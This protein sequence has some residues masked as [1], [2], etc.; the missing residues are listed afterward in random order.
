MQV[1]SDVTL[2]IYL[3]IDWCIAQQKVNNQFHNGLQTNTE[4]KIES[5]ISIWTEQL[6]RTNEA[7]YQNGMIM[8]KIVQVAG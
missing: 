3:S 5:K 1:L 6:W 2:N 7:L 8:E 4:L